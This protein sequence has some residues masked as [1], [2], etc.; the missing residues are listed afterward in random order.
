MATIQPIALNDSELFNEPANDP[1]YGQDMSTQ[2]GKVHFCHVPQ[3][4]DK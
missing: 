3:L 2:A 4:E 1:Y